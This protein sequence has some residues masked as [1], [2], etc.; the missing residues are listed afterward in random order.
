VATPMCGKRTLR[1]Q[2]SGDAEPTKLTTDQKQLILDEE[3][4]AWDLGEPLLRQAGFGDWAAF[5]DRREAGL[6]I[7]GC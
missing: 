3:R 1:Q 7:I 5:F 4:R 2:S 6:V